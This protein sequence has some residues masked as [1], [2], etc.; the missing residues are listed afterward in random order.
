M[1]I[2]I[3]LLLLASFVALIE[4]YHPNIYK[5][6]PCGRRCGRMRGGIRGGAIG[7]GVG[8]S[9]GGGG[10]RGGCRGG[11]CGGGAFRQPFGSGF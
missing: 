9:V 7:V 5:R 11:G 10:C 1:N 6:Q 3:V 8:V 2:K 4:C